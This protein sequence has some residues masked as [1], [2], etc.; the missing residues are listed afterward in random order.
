MSTSL[1]KLVNHLSEIVEIKTEN[2]GVFFKGSKNNK[3]FF[4]CS[5]CKR[6]QL[7]PIIGLIKKFQILMHT[8][9][10]MEIS[11]NFFCC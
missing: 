1:S 5:K 3:L 9:F 6:K 10:V 11:I 7:K 4:R 8:N 2:L